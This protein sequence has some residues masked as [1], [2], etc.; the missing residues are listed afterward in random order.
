MDAVSAAKSR[1]DKALALLERK[2]LDLKARPASAPPIADDDLFA[3]RPSNA[4][5]VAR[6]EALESAGRDA[7]DALARAAEAVREVMAANDAAHEDAPWDEA[8][9]LD[10]EEAR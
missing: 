10:Q 7:A 4:S 5:D 2:V 8:D 3:P 9:D 6:I 1:I